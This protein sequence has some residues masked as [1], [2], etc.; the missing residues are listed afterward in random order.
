M[1][2]NVLERAITL[3]APHHCLGCGVEDTLLCEQCATGITGLVPPRCYRCHA[4]TQQSK[5]C[6]NCRRKVS[7]LRVWVAAEYNGLAKDLLYKLKF[8][9][10]VS[11]STIVAGLLDETLPLLPKGTVVTY[12]P[13]TNSRVRLR[14]YDQSKCIAKQLAFRRKLVFEELLI[15]RTSSRQVGVDRKTRFEQLVNA[16]EPK[17]TTRIK[18]AKILLIDDVLTTGA[19]IESAS[20]VLMKSGAKQVEAAVFATA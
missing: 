19:T 18:G 15:R 12:V 11:A 14:G 20:A 6:P 8:E 3:L 2:M 17:S 7:L 5:V 16:F 13:T 4:V 10:A 9:R 1:R